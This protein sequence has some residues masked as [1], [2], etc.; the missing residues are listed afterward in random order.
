MYMDMYMYMEVLLIYLINY[1]IN[2]HENFNSPISYIS[3]FL[4]TLQAVPDP[5]DIE[6]MYKEVSGDLDRLQELS[7]EN[8]KLRTEL[9]ELQKP[10][11]VDGQGRGTK[12]VSYNLQMSC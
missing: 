8:A 5:S 4:H 11:E 12:N 6:L 7:D 1:L 9:H 3:S 10:S 2:S